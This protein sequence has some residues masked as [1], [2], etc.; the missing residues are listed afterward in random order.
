MSPWQPRNRR[1]PSPHPDFVVLQ[2]HKI[3]A[4]LDAKYRDLWERSLPHNMLCQLTIYAATHPQHVATILYPPVERHATESR[5]A[6]REPIYWTDIGQ[7]QL[8][9]VVLQTLEELINER[10][11]RNKESYANWLAF[12][13]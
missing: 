7:V 2:G 9:P 10:S 4:I 12:G 1:S 6:L 8:R 13:Q 11:A 3:R 5:V